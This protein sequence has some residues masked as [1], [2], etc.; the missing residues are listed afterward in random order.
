MAGYQELASGLALGGAVGL[1]DTLIM[2]VGIQRSLPQESQK[3][4]LKP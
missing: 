4:R 2:F 3:R 1:L